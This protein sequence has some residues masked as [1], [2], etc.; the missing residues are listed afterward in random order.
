MLAAR[1][2]LIKGSIR[3][4]DG[5]LEWLSPRDRAGYGQFWFNGKNHRAHRIAYRVWNGAIP[6]GFFVLHHCDNTWCIEPTHLFVGTHLMNMLDSIQKGR[7]KETRKT[8]C[9]KGHSYTEFGRTDSR[10]KRECTECRRNRNRR[11]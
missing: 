10:G 7:H 3:R 8:H 5:C 9:P 11:K 6:K 1:A 2:R 4:P